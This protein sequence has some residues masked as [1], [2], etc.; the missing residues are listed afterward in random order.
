[1]FDEEVLSVF[2]GLTLS[3]SN[4]SANFSFLTQTQKLTSNHLEAIPTQH[5]FQSCSEKICTPT[6]LS[7]QSQTFR[8]SPAV[9]ML[10]DSIALEV[11][12][13]PQMQQHKSLKKAVGRS[14]AYFSP[15]LR[16]KRKNA[17]HECAAAASSTICLFL[18][19]VLVCLD[20]A[21]PVGAVDPVYS[22]L[23]TH[24]GPKG[25]RT[26]RFHYFEE[27]SVCVCVGGGIIQFGHSPEQTKIGHGQ[28]TCV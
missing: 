23:C 26:T 20:R 21:P 7:R 10:F 8:P 11:E 12:T 27:R 13:K 4:N 6:P 22:C 15:H 14:G 3:S 28:H 9:E 1:M 19:A 17:A 16:R 2:D 5:D 25:S 24:T 18:N